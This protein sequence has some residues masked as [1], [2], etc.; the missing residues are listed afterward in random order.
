MTDQNGAKVQKFSGLGWLAK[1]HRS[2]RPKHLLL[3]PNSSWCSVPQQICTIP[4]P[5]PAT[6]ILRLKSIHRRLGFDFT[7]TRQEAAG[8]RAAKAGRLHHKLPAVRPPKRGSP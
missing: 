4:I 2:T 8:S 7:A 6:T 1:H 3:P 5:G